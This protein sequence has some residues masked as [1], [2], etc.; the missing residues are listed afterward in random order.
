MRRREVI[1]GLG[2]LSATPLFLRVQ[3]P[4]GGAIQEPTPTFDFQEPLKCAAGI[5]PW[6]RNSYRLESERFTSHPAKFVVHNY[7]HGGAGITLS[8]GVASKA[9]DI[10][11]AHLATTSDRDVAVIGSGVIGLTTATRLMELGLRVTIYAKEFWD[12]TTSHVAGGQWAP[13]KVE[14]ADTQQFKDILKISYKTFEQNIGTR[15]GISKVPNYTKRPQEDLDEVIRLFAG[16]EPLIPAPDRLT[17]PFGHN[18]GS[19]Y[20][21]QTLLIEP[22]IF[23]KQLHADLV[24]ANVPFISRRFSSPRDVLSLRENIIVNCTGFEAKQLWSDN[25]IVPAKGQ[26]ALLPPQPNLK[27][28]FS[29]SGQMFPRTDAIVIGGTYEE[30]STSPTSDVEVCRG[31]VNDI[32][33]VFGVGPVVERF[34]IHI[35][36]PYNLQDLAPKK[37]DGEPF[38]NPCGS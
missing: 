21:Y 28:L 27:Y 38:R 33:A 23:L 7:G 29:R 12:K 16:E 3:Q 11:R 30:C 37:G 25:D 14:Y 20:R 34:A 6:R 32:K 26:L 8:W 19:G 17:L 1:F 36:H 9:R 13:S 4:G 18:M 15:F 31:L 22:P 5:R 35:D 24:A 10:V 2:G